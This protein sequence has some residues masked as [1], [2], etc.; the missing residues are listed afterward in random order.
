LR[1]LVSHVLWL[2]RKLGRDTGV[3]TAGVVLKECFLWAWHV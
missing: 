3:H 1:V 2:M